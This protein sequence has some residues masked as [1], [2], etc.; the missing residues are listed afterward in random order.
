MKIRNFYYKKKI[1]CTIYY[2]R[3]IEDNEFITNQKSELQ[4]GFLKYKKNHK[5]KAHFHP[6]RLR[7]IYNTL[8]VLHLIKGKVLLSLY[9]PKSYKKFKTIEISAGAILI[10]YGHGHSFEYLKKSYIIEVKQGP[11]IIKD[12]K[13]I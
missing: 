2:P 9:T 6:R 5:V 7:K 11:Y 12:K 13:I 1:L 8:E 10:L 3:F 4:V